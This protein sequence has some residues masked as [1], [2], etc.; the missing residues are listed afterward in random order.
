MGVGLA[1]A[2]CGDSI[3]T[4]L[5]DE[6]TVVLFDTDDELSIYN[7]LKKLLSRP[8]WARQIAHS[9]QNYI[10]QNHQVSRMVNLLIENYLSVQNQYQLS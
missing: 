5:R 9:G 4:T 7:A 6:K 8:E 2:S 10:R 3:L 1:V